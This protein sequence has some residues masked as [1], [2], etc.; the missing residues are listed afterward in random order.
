MGPNVLRSIK[1]L[2]V[3]SLIAVSSMT[4]GSLTPV[5]LLWLGHPGTDQP[6]PV[7]GRWNGLI[8]QRRWCIGTYLRRNCKTYSVESGA[9]G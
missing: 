6:F 3:L 7:R 5:R 8:V 4:T 9:G 2:V 1:A